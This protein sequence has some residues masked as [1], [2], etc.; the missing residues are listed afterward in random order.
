[1]N[2]MEYGGKYTG[3]AGSNITGRKGGKAPFGRSFSA[4][5]SLF[6]FIL[7]QNKCNSDLFSFSLIFVILDVAIWI[8][9]DN[10]NFILKS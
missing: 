3:F 5:T 8:D 9:N 4:S 6:S 10:V 7:L 1:M 2:T